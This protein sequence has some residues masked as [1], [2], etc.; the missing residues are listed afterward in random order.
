MKDDT[1]QGTKR[2]I[3]YRRLWVD[4]LISRDKMG[5]VNEENT[6]LS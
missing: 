5:E 6:S 1:L 2:L 4:G 3:K